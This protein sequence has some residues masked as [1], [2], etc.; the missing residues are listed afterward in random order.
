MDTEVVDVLESEEPRSIVPI[1]EELV[2]IALQRSL[3]VTAEYFEVVAIPEDDYVPTL[4]GISGNDPVNLDGDAFSVLK[5]HACCQRVVLVGWGDVDE[6]A[7]AAVI[8]GLL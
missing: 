1:L 7:R 3:G 6:S 5:R 8:P 4:V 2:A